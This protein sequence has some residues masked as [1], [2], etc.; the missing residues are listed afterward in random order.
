MAAAD[1]HL[2]DVDGFS[3]S[4]LQRRVALAGAMRPILAQPAGSCRL[5]A[6]T[7]V[8]SIRDAVWIAG[9]STSTCAV[10]AT[11]ALQF[12][13]ALSGLSGYLQHVVDNQNFGVMVD[14]SPKCALTVAPAQSI[15]IA[16]TASAEK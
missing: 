5:L 12:N 14:M 11:G 13:V 1:R 9:T 15:P 10:R 2:L 16:K 3:W 8:A 4:E 6:D 7:P